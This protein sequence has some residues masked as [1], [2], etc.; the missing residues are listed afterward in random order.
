[1]GT[2]KPGAT[3]IYERNGS[4]V[5]ARESGSSERKLVGYTYDGE[6]V[7][8][9]SDGLK[10]LADHRLWNEIRAAAKSNKSLQKAMERVIII[11][12]LSKDDP[13]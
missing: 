5:Y 13:L 10:D 8:Q 2:L 3:Y 1:M 12:R 6:G 4:E 9:T 7:Y 11:Y